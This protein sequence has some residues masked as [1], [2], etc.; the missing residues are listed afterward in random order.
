[1]D[2]WLHDN[3]LWLAIVVLV[4]GSIERGIHAL[5]KNIIEVE[6]QTRKAVEYLRRIA[7]VETRVEQEERAREE[8]REQLAREREEEEEEERGRKEREREWERRREEE[9]KRRAILSESQRSKWHELPKPPARCTPYE[10]LQKL[11]DFVER[12]CGGSVYD[13]GI[14][15]EV[16]FAVPQE[17][18]WEKLE[19]NKNIGGTGEPVQIKPTDFP[20][21]PATMGRK[22]AID[23]LSVDDDELD[24]ITRL[25][26]GAAPE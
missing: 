23:L 2:Q 17:E 24:Q 6:E 9:E 3:W 4:L 26:T 8:V 5:R 25:P 19:A 11:K 1:M 21:R 13:D 12:R 18:L 22:L 10:R 20:R 14:A 7:D 16:E 15:S